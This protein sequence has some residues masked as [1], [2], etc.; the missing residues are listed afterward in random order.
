MRGWEVVG[1][2]DD[3]SK[4]AYSGKSREGW[5]TIKSMMRERSVDLVIAWKMDRIT[6]TVRELTD[7]IALSR[8]TGV[9]IVTTEGDF[10]LSNEAGKMMATVL[11]AVAEME[12]ERK[13]A[14][15]KRANQQRREV[16]NR[17]ASGWRPFGYELDGTMIQE[18]A[19]LIRRAATDVLAGTPLREIARQWRES[20]VSTPRSAKGSDGWT[21]NGVR[22]ILLNP[23]NAGLNTYKGEVVGSGNWEPIFPEDVHVRIKAKL[24]DPSRLTNRGRVAVN[25]LSGI[26]VCAVCEEPATGGTATVYRRKDDDEA[27]PKRTAVYKC[28]NDHISTSREEADQ[29]VVSAFKLSLLTSTEFRTAQLMPLNKRGD[30]IADLDR[31]ATRINQEMH[32]LATSLAEGRITLPQMETATSALQRQLS[33]IE[34]ALT[35]ATH[36]EEDERVLVRE[37]V[38]RFGDMTTT[39]QREILRRVARIRLFPKRRGKRNVP[40]KHQVEMDLLTFDRDGAERVIPALAERPKDGVSSVRKGEQA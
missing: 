6:R 12:V 1:V 25:L 31:D 32:A 17:W 40:I 37:N 30:D 29:L 38:E 16:G 2:V 23:R 18:E 7:I 28:P 24:T 26:A 14:R 11:G 39:E 10:D 15:Q 4:S 13:G 36:D 8:E 35:A 9:A 34:T 3:I 21:H 27:S 5:E 22:S 19:D 33:T 20:G